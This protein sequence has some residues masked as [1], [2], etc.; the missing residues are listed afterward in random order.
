MREVPRRARQEVYGG[1]GPMA[2]RPCP[3]LSTDCSWLSPVT[4]W[5]S[6]R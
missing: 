4:I 1:T 6:R 2:G 3:S 5:G